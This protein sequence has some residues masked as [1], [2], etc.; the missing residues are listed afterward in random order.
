MGK[1]NK[2]VQIIN[3]SKKA[4]PPFSPTIYGKRQILPKP[5]AHPTVARITP[6]LL[7]NVAL[8]VDIF[9]LLYEFVDF[10]SFIDASSLTTPSRI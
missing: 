8:F 4:A 1:P 3:T 5:T 2:T 9:C 6:S 10:Y 7:P